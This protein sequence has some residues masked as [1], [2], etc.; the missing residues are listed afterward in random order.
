[1]ADNS[2]QEII[3]A[4]HESHYCI[5]GNDEKQYKYYRKCISQSFPR[6]AIEEFINEHLDIHDEEYKFSPDPGIFIS[7]LINKSK[8]ERFNLNFREKNKDIS[9]LGYR[10]NKIIT[11]EGNV[12][13]HLGKKMESGLITLNGDCLH[14]PGMRMKDGTI[15]ING[16]TPSAGLYVEGGKII[17]NSDYEDISIGQCLLGGTLV[18]NGELSGKFTSYGFR[19]EIY[20]KDR[21]VGKDGVIFHK[22]GE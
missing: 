14:Y 1:M 22:I 2:L 20:H 18:F 8:E 12:G 19:G 6:D 7:A 3:K 10:N 16:K 17:V 4:Y 21:L 15:I 13:S 11:I 5:D 9:I